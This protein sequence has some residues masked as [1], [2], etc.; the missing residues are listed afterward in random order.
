MSRK[1]KLPSMK[2][3]YTTLK[4]ITTVK[5]SWANFDEIRTLQL[6]II[7]PF[8]GVRKN[9]PHWTGISAMTCLLAFKCFDL[10]TICHCRESLC[11]IDCMKYNWIMQRYSF[12]KYRQTSN[13]S[14]TKFQN[15]NV[16]H[17]VSQL[18]SPNPSKPCVKSRMKMQLGQPT[19]F[20]C[21]SGCPY[22]TQLF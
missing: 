15:L 18:S 11:L 22:I 21:L 12:S 7:D 4:W 16:Y 5:V 3:E 2:I 20:H 6:E 8:D 14:R 19:L 17:L 10:P 9:L 1:C 13:V